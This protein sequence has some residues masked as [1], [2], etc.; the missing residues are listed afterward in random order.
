MGT[1]DVDSNVTKIIE[2]LYG[3]NNI[4]VSIPITLDVEHMNYDSMRELF[5][6]HCSGFGVDHHLQS[7]KDLPTYN[8]EDWRRIDNIVKMWN[9]VPYHPLFS[10][11]PQN[12]NAMLMLFGLTLRNCFDQIMIQFYA[13]RHYIM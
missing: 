4:W 2:K 11:N 6:T 3:I 8:M 10:N 1:S 13:T 7:P 12:E 9:T 5:K